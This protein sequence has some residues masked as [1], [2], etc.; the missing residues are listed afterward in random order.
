MYALPYELYVER[1]VRRWVPFTCSSTV[2]GLSVH[3]AAPHRSRVLQM[4]L[5]GPVLRPACCCAGR[6]GPCTAAAARRP[7]SKAASRPAPVPLAPRPVNRTLLRAC[8]SVTQLRLPRHQLQ[9]PYRRGGG[10][11]GG[12]WWHGRGSR[13]ACTTGSGGAKLRRRGAPGSP[14]ACGLP[15][16]LHSTRGH[17][18][19]VPTA[20]MSTT[21]RLTR[22]VAH[23]LPPSAPCRPPA[24]WAS[25]RRRP[26]S[27]SA[28][29]APGRACAPSRCGAACVPPCLPPPAVQAGC[30]ARA[31][32]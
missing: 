6:L 25:P 18:M 32:A 20:N 16:I 19:C 9:V 2:T 23:S 13:P 29:W 1:A 10:R 5:V 31:R 7:C 4:V 17:H 15:P 27:S 3:S 12:A 30:L 11:K 28:T 22:P 8:L 21:G 14:R 26:T 24:S